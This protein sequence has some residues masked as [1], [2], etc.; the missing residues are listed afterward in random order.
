MKIAYL[1]CFSGISGD[2]FLG[3]LLDAGLSFEIREG[4][5]PPTTCAK[6]SGLPSGV[7]ELIG[8]HREEFGLAPD[9]GWG[10][11]V[12]G[13]PGVGM[14]A[15]THV[16]NTVAS[17]AGQLTAAEMEGRRQIR[18][19]M[20]IARKYGG[21]SNKP[22]LLDFLLSGFLLAF[23]LNRP[24]SRLKNLRFRTESI[25]PVAKCILRCTPRL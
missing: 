14:C 24:L 11:P 21:P 25:S 12:P 2:M 3:A 5:Q 10:A 20:D 15:Y 4:L 9:H 19:Y 17:D 6:I 23:R 1:D 16:F 22:C 18:A 7:L 8:K 13:S